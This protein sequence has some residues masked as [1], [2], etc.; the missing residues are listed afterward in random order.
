MPPSLPDVRQAGAS[1]SAWRSSV[2]ETALFDTGHT[3]AASIVS[4]MVIP[5]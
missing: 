5:D 2:Y 1:A 4:R 3:N